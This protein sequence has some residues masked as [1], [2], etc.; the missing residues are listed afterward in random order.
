MRLC[1]IR[2][3]NSPAMEHA[4]PVAVYR[5]LTQ[6]DPHEDLARVRKLAEL[7]DS[8]F[9]VFGIRFGIDALVGLIP[10]VGDSITALIGL[11]PIYVAQ[12]HRISFFVRSRMF[13]HLLADWL[14]GLIPLVGDIFDIG[15]KA[16]LKNLRLL[17]KAMEERGIRTR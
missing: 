2:F 7:L 4:I 3:A 6:T 15:Y 13:G 5:R 8:K 14:V 12:Q 10:V 9:S 1:G 11:Y 16:N 17:E